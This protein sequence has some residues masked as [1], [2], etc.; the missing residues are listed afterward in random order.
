MKTK[1]LF[2]AL[3]IAVSTTAF[4]FDNG[5]PSMTVVAFKGSEIFKVIYKGTTTGKVRMNILDQRGNVIH[6]ESFS[7]LNGF[8]L[9]VNFKGLQSGTYT[10]ELIDNAGKYQELVNYRPA[11][12]LKSIHVTKLVNENG[13]FLLAVA[14]AQ[15]EPIRIRIFD[16]DQRV[17]YNDSKVV[18]GDFA[19]VYKLENAYSRYTFE[20]S[21]EKGYK[22]YFNF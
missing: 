14:N 10:I 15:S 7:G 17:I 1:A 2:F 3:L 12:E 9:P 19:Q 11:H 16:Q 22:K 18:T 6:S 21:D 5:E 4:G 20:V 8:I 13:K